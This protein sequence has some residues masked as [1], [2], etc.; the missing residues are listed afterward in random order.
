V[1]YAL[2]FPGQGAQFVG[3]GSSLFEDLPDLLGEPA[4][5]TLGWSLRDACLEGPADYL[6]RTDIAQPALYALSYAAWTL[7][8]DR[9]GP[10]PSAAAGHSLGEY[11]ALAAAGA[12]D[13]F[14]GLA[15]VAARGRAMAAAAAAAPSGM[16]AVVGS[17]AAELEG[18]CAAR[19]G[20]GG[21]LWVANLNAPGQT[22]VAGTAEDVAWLLERSS[23]LGLRRV[24]SLE[25][26]GAFH[27]PLMDPAAAT[28]AAELT[29]RTF[30]P[31]AFPV[32]SNVDAAPYD[33]GITDGL[34][35]QL[36]S[37][38][39]FAESLSGIAGT[40]IKAFLHVGPGA[41]TTG[42]ARRTVDGATAIA[43]EDGAGVAAAA[44][45]LGLSIE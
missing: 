16:A 38:V 10:L 18:I 20:E 4:D 19:R 30:G 35:R 26:A 29:G 43:V 40:G 31:L 12:F 15:L 25:V 32:W 28:F 8:H 23:S 34:L 1:D 21:G 7:W 2:L 3:M 37:P 14:E 22:V 9:V 27:S 36:T 24:I 17:D 13:F 11:T 33:A 41:V 45:E 44:A 6:T 5:A 42:M 39:R